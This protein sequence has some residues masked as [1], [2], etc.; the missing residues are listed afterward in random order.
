MFTVKDA[1]TVNGSSVQYIAYCWAEKEGY[2]KFGSYRGAGS[3]NADDGPMIIT[4]FKPA[5]VLI[6]N[7]QQSG[8]DWILHNNESPGYNVNNKYFYANTNNEEISA[9]TLQLDL[10]SNGFK[11]RKS[12][13]AFNNNNETMIYM[14]FGEAPLVGSNNVP[15]TAR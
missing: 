12:T 15:A 5:W 8:D 4:G 2:S 3:V 7:R 11:I 10:L 14:A 6:K 9:D 1:N 13:G